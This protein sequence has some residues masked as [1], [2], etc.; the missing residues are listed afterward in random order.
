[1]RD[2]DWSE[3][4][5]VN[6]AV[7]LT[8]SSVSL[9]ERSG[10]RMG[11]KQ[12]G[13]VF[14]YPFRPFFECVLDVGKGNNFGQGKCPWKFL[15]RDA[16]VSCQEPTCLGL[17]LKAESGGIYHSIHHHVGYHDNNKLSF[18]FQPLCLTLSSI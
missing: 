14:V 12:R 3:E 16:V 11:L 6:Y 10:T 18:S 4:E 9:T 8:G 13:Q 2:E 17:V 1:M 15:G 7:A 5:E